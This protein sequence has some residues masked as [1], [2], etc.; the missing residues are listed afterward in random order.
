MMADNEPYPIVRPLVATDFHEWLSM[1][2]GYNEFYG[3]VGETALPQHITELTWARLLDAGE[4]MGA[5]VA[6]LAGKLVGIAHFLFHRST[7]SVELTC[8]LQDLFTAPEARGR[9]IATMLIERSYDE[10]AAAGCR[11]IYWQTH[12]TNTV[13]RQLYD[14]VAE[15]S[16]FIV[17]R[18]LL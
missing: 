3:R 4:P 12:K 10:A 14:R 17:Y 8:Y 1:W 18:K 2:R 11:R 6:E 5:L 13:A 15:Q 9:G 7:I 16:G